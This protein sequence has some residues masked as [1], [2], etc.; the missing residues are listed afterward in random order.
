MSRW[1]SE[2]RVD[3]ERPADPELREEPGGR[4]LFAFEP[5]RLDRP[6]LDVHFADAPFLLRIPAA[7]GPW[8]ALPVFALPGEHIDVQRIAVLHRPAI[9]PA[10][11]SAGNDPTP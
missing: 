6:Q 7:V 3:V 8:G 9:G 11:P 4:W 1:P 5:R 2:R 10:H